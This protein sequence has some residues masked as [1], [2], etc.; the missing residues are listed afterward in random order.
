M[1]KLDFILKNNIKIREYN[2]WII[3]INKHSGAK[4]IKQEYTFM[5]PSY[6]SNLLNFRALKLWKV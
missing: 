1:L 2:M 5:I 6:K 4:S 3:Q